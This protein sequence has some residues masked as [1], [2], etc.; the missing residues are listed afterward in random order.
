MLPSSAA[1]SRVIWAFAFIA[2]VAV[3]IVHLASGTSVWLGPSTLAKA[4][5]GQG[6]P[7][8]VVIVQSIRAP[9]LVACWLSGAI[10]GGIGAV[11]QAVFRNPL[12]EPY[13]VG[14]SSGAALGGVTVVLAG[15]A[16][17]ASGLGLMGGA[18][19]GGL[20]LLA[21]VL[22][23]GRTRVDPMH[24]LLAGVALGAMISGLVTVMLVTGGQDTN[25][26]VGWLFGATD[27][28]MPTQ[29]YVIAAAG[30]LGL[31]WILRNARKLDALALGD[32][33]AHS[34]GLS[35]AVWRGRFLGVGSVL[36]SLV[37]GAVGVIG[38]VGLI[39]PHA[40][41]R[42][43]PG[44]S[45]ATILAATVLGAFLLTAADLIAQRATGVIAV[46]VG[47]MTAILGA[48][49]MVGLLRRSAL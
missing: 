6:D 34:L 8:T 47:A 26:V 27:R 39:A 18:L 16:S 32:T 5:F 42:L 2:L 20:L 12:A 45:R 9:R 11:F 15:F 30:V 41:R 17:A 37:V 21:L 28:A 14:V 13:V 31:A 3:S 4:L 19:V 38:F 46:P 40:A 35:V 44:D 33:D 24:L 48:P 1:R 22:A 7:G 25:R 10:L 23:I 36:T 29:L 43:T 49:L